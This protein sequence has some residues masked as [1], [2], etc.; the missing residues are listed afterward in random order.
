MNK[1]T[2]ITPA[3]EVIDLM[4]ESNMLAGSTYNDNEEIGPDEVLS[5]G[6]RGSWGNLWDKGE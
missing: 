5:A 2:Y 1:K 4:V 3:I 6:R